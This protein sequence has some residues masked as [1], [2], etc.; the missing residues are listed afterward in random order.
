[1]KFLK[2]IFNLGSSAF[3]AIIL[4]TILLGGVSYYVYEQFGTWSPQM[5]L[6]FALVWWLSLNYVVILLKNKK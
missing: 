6:W 5:C 4:P 2:E 1:M 3:V